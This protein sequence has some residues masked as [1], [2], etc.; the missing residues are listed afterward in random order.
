MPAA[1]SLELVRSRSLTVSPIQ[2]FDN[3]FPRTVNQDF[4][5]QEGSA[6]QYERSN[7]EKLAEI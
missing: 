5:N 1:G 7:R 2:L 4:G 6:I 3:S